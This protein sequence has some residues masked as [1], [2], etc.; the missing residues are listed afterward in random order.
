MNEELWQNFYSWRQ[1][2][3]SPKTLHKRKTVHLHYLWQRE[4][5]GHKKDGVGGK[6][7]GKISRDFDKKMYICCQSIHMS[8]WLY[9]GERPFICT[10]C[11]KGFCESGNLKKQMILTCQLIL[12]TDFCS[13]YF[14]HPWGRKLWSMMMVATW[15]SNLARVMMMMVFLMSSTWTMGVALHDVFQTSSDQDNTNIMALAFGEADTARSSKC[16]QKRRKGE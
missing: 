3:S 5:I 6:D 11:G 8:R 1:D 7:G 15:M 9:T 13:K 4:E 16:W 12:V 10:T 2:D 14:S